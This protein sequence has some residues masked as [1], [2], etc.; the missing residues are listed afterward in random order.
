MLTSSFNPKT[1]DGLMCRYQ[2][3]IGWDGMIYDCNF[4]L[5]LGLSVNYRAPDHIPKL[6]VSSLQSL[7]NRRVVT[8][9]HCFGCTASNGPSFRGA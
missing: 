4:N 7:I 1:V 2:I 6:N 5:A 3:N 9:F 8:G